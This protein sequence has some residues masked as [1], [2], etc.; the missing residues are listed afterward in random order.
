MESISLGC[1][2]KKIINLHPDRFPNCA[3]PMMSRVL[4]KGPIYIVKKILVGFSFPNRYVVSISFKL[5]RLRFDA[6]HFLKES[7][8]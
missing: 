4:A 7:Y 6:L 3:E 5:C 8:L 1:L 2:Q